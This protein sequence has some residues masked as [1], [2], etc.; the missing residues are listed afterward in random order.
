M[1]N[2][3]LIFD[4]SPVLAAAADR[5]L[6]PTVE[7]VAWQARAAAGSGCSSSRA[8]GAQT[9][10]TWGCMHSHRPPSSLLS[11]LHD[12]GWVREGKE[13]CPPTPHPPNAPTLTTLDH[14]LT[15]AMTTSNTPILLNHIAD[16]LKIMCVCLVF[17]DSPLQTTNPRALRGARTD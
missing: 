3:S 5:R 7:L 16:F 15:V 12:L 13:P 11:M 9:W 8:T 1:T 6:G 10:L 17:A 2:T 4:C 14:H